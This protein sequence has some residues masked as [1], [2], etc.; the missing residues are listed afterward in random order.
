MM[1][2]LEQ[3]QQLPPT[4][5]YILLG[6]FGLIVGSFLNVCIFRM[7][8]EK[9]IV[10]PRSF[11]PKCR[12]PIKWYDNV[13]LFSYIVLL[14]KCRECKRRIPIQY[15]LVEIISAVASVF[16]FYHFQAWTPYLIYY[17]LLISPLI[18]V[19][20]IDL[21]HLI[22]P[23]L[24]S[25]PGIFVGAASQFILMHGGWL[26][27]GKDVLLGIVVGGGFLAIVGFSYEWL[28]KRE[29]LGGGDIKL[30]AMLGAFFGWKGVIFILL[31]SSVLG[32]VV[33]ILFLVIYRKG[34][35]YAIP[36]GPFLAAAAIIYLFWGD[37]ILN[38]YLG[39]I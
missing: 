23:D 9:S 18:I 32:S 13:P 11:C 26:D 10:A 34:L 5:T 2:V 24:I 25:I 14:G 27:I 29:G 12:T 38:W 3:I 37:L 6:I 1:R 36:Y 16:T 21:P 30:A 39:L 15:P 22:I 19:T 4:A 31:M 20:F 17:L 8:R 28:K 7:P 35:K 33:G